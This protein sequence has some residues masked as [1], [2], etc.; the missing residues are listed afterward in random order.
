MALPSS[1][2]RRLNSPAATSRPRPSRP[3]AAPATAG[4]LTIDAL[5]AATGAS[6]RTIRFYQS[7]GVLMPPE[8]RG[9]T[10]LYGRD[11]VERLALVELLQR[12]GLRLRAIRDLLST[13]ATDIPASVDGWLG[14]G[15][16]L[17][18]PWAPEAGEELTGAELRERLRGTGA[19]VAPMLQ[20][21][22]VETRG[23][24]AYRVTN[25]RLFAVVAALGRAGIDATA[26]IGAGAILR[27]HLGAAADELVSHFAGRVGRGFAARATPE[28]VEEALEALRP[29]AVEAVQLI[30]TAEMER[31]L[32]ELTAVEDVEDVGDAGVSRVRSPRR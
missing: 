7:A 26:A 16:R 24:H 29:L 15:R 5:S 1:A 19:T 22:L 21:R 23:R 3:P 8:R 20:A 14:L 30:F 9:R 12:R 6:S 25:S 10:A 2:A 4:E 17:A 32:R 13:A 11:H 27:R 28:A 18:R 31:H